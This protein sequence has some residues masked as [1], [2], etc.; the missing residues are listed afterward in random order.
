MTGAHP[1]PPP[2]VP[3]PRHLLDPAAIVSILPHVVLAAFESDPFRVRYRLTGTRIDE[4]TG[5]NVT[6]KYLD[7]LTIGADAAIFKPMIENY[8]HAW[9]SG[10]AVIDYYQWT[11]ENGRVMP[12]CYGIFPLT[13]EGKIRQAIAI[14][15]QA[16]EDIADPP[17][18]RLKR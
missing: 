8:R 4:M 18:P 12:V 15:E 6:G 16:I 5:A 14:E 17:K 2:L 13:I 3:P 9:Q 10:E 1:L 7:A 11:T